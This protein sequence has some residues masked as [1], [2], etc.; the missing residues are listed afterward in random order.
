MFNRNITANL[1]DALSDSP[2]VLL[3]GARQAGKSTLVKAIAAKEHPAR[4][5][6]LDDVSV[7]AAIRHDPAGF[8][9]GLDGPVIIDEVQRAPELFVSIKA[10]VDRDRQPGRYLLTGSANVLLLPKLSESLAGRMEILSLWP[11]SQGELAGVREGLVDALFADKLPSITPST[12]EKG[13]LLG[14]LL[15]GGYPEVVGRATEAR[16]RAWFNSYLMT[17]LQRDVRDLANIEGLT[18]LPRLLSL[19]ATRSAGLINF[20]EL[21]RTSTIPQ[22]T[23]KRYMSLLETTFLVQHLPAWSGNLGKRLVKAAKL[24]LNDTG[25]MAYLLGATSE[26]MVSEGLV[27]PLLENFVVMELRKQ[28]TWSEIQPQMFHWRTQT[29][30]EVDILL[31]DARGRIVGIEVKASAT[32]GSQDFKG[33]KTLA[34]ATGDRFLRGIVLYTGRES[35]PYGSSLHALPVDALWRAGASTT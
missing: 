23:L 29:G 17:I 24:V 22:S 19:L 6:T 15:C 21:S 1:L 16:R 18:E 7:L 31:E 11:L 3:N 13:T 12:E 20:A 35:I 34:E 27:G 14:R 25:L 5:L 10:E 30:Q 8:L 4:Y 26:R 2:V 28:L 32:V 9:A 33:L